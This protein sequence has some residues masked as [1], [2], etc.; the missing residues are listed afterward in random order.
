[1]PGNFLTGVLEEVLR[2]PLRS[3]ISR[4]KEAPLACHQLQ[5]NINT[6]SCRHQMSDED[7]LFLVWTSAIRSDTRG[8]DREV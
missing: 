5:V 7:H 2:I 6:I 8:N 4:A 3:L 1:M